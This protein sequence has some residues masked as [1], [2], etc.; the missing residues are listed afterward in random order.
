LIL[1]ITLIAGCQPAGAPEP[2]PQSGSQRMAPTSMSVESTP[3]RYFEIEVVDDQS[4]RGVPLVELT[5]VSNVRYWTDSNGLVAV[6]DPALIGHQVF[7]RV[8]SDGYEFPADGFGMHGKAFAI[9]PGGHAKIAVHRT[10]IAERL[11]RLTGEG[12]YRDTVLL[13]HAS[14]TSQPLLNAQ[15]TGQDSVQSAAYHGKIYWFFGDTNR[16]SYPL[17]HFGTA[18]ATSEL[19]GHGGLDPEVGVDLN[20]FTDARGFS[21]PMFKAS[22]AHPRWLDGLVVLKDT[23]G[24]ERLVGKCDTHKSLEAVLERDL[25]VFNDADAAFESVAKLPLDAP[26]HPRGHTFLLETQGKTWCY[27]CDPFPNVRVPADLESMKDPTRYEAFTPLVA[28]SRVLPGNARVTD[29]QFDRGDDGKFAWAW[30]PNTAPLSYE[31]QAALIRSGKMSVAEARFCPLDVETGK[32]VYLA[33]GSVCFNA[34]RNKWIMIASQWGGKTSFLG[35]V[36]YAE[37]QQP[38][39]P[40]MRARHILTHDRYSFYNPAQHPYFD[41]QGGQ[42]IYFEGTYAG[43][44][45]RDSDLTPRYDYNQI[46]YRLDLSD[47]R[48]ELGK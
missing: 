3:A 46:M 21:R 47:P 41:Q 10:N 25:V 35:E 17:G 27:F 20:Y 6:D 43:T 39:G 1:A 38:E 23:G 42:V 4:G 16:Q 48:L 15:V 45:S 7:F 13:G 29:L 36:W 33:T 34:Y 31:Q 9:T 32:P 18:G 44:F 12:V 22:G 24:V 2:T 37:A 26:L 28:G 5:T 19:P 30:K 8:R 14:P 11:Y 40:W